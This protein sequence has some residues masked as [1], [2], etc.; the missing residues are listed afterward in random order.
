MFEGAGEGQGA[1]QIAKRE[2]RSVDPGWRSGRSPATRERLRKR[3]STPLRPTLQHRTRI[4]SHIRLIVVRSRTSKV[5]CLQGFRGGADF[6]QIDAASCTWRC[7][8]ARLHA[9]LR[10]CGSSGPCGGRSGRNSASACRERRAAAPRPQQQHGRDEQQRDHEL[11]LRRGLGGLLRAVGGP[12][13]ARLSAWAARVAASGAPWRSARLSAAT[14]GA[15]RA[16]RARSR[17]SSACV[18]RLP[19]VARAAAARLS[20]AASRPG[21]RRPTSCS[22]RRG[23]S[24]AAIATRSRSSTSGSS[25]SI[26]R[27]RVRARRPQR[28]LGREIAGERRGERASAIPSRPGATLASGSTASVA[29]SASPACSA[30]ISLVGRSMPAAAARAARPPLGLRPSARAELGD[31]AE[32]AWRRRV[33]GRARAASSVSRPRRRATPRWRVRRSRGTGA[34]RRHRE[35]ST[36]APA[37]RRRRRASDRALARATRARHG[38]RSDRSLARRLAA[39]SR[40]SA[41]RAHCSR[42]PGGRFRRS[43]QT[44]RPPDHV[45]REAA[46]GEQRDDLQQQREA[47]QPGGDRVAEQAGDAARAGRARPAAR[48]RP[49]ARAR[50]AR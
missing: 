7:S 44:I 37:W 30:T 41:P 31:Q 24:P 32:R 26:A 15:V 48:R 25:A 16:G 38:E 21:W 3:Q 50:S 19:H 20:S 8:A 40:R 5:A 18:G 11:D 2:G 36:V 17:S 47:G 10:L 4:A 27:A 22:A 23:A 34:A 46:D 13:G 39:A 9:V 35:R 42:R 14:S 43:G 12:L 6:V 28:V 29:S 1:C 33:R 45:A 49:A